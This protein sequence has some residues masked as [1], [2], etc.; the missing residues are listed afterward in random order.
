MFKKIASKVSV[1]LSVALSLGLAVFILNF[2]ACIGSTPDDKEE[3]SSSSEE[4]SSS[5]YEPPEV[6][7]DS[8]KINNFLLEVSGIEDQYLRITGS[9]LMSV[10]DTTLK[11]LVL[12]SVNVI[13]GEGKKIN[14]NPSSWLRSYAIDLNVDIS[15]PK[16]CGKDSDERERRVCVAAYMRESESPA[17]VE[18]K[19]FERNEA[20][21]AIPSSSSVESSSSAAVILQF[22]QITFEGDIDRLP[23]HNSPGVGYRG[24]ILATGV[25]TDNPNAADFYL[26]EGGLRT[27]KNNV[28]IVSDFYIN[29]SWR[30]FKAASI[31]PSPPLQNTSGFIFRNSGYKV[32]SYTY[33]N[34]YV[35]RTSPSSEWNSSCYLV[36]AASTLVGGKADI[37]VWRVVEQ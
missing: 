16:Y 27:D 31:P 1:S 11:G 33:L 23:I 29:G 20:K 10:T 30:P 25:P 37:M 22:E 5:V 32:E 35:I 28:D 17:A 13:M 14:S 4:S 15:D 26:G 6:E 18:C 2:S 21:C 12:D 7:P 8:V 36:L 9:V 19:Y 34:Y 24:V 3:P